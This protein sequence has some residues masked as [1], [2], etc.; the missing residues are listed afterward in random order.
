M[1]AGSR[2]GRAVVRIH[3]LEAPGSSIDLSI[4]E[5]WSSRM[6]SASRTTTTRCAASNGLKA[7]SRSSSR[8]IESRIEAAF[9]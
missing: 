7:S 2:E 8:V 5:Y 9:S 1:V 3:T 6:R 4:A